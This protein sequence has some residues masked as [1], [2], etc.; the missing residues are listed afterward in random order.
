ML[1]LRLELI[2]GLR[3]TVKTIYKCSVSSVFSVMIMNN[4]GWVVSRVLKTKTNV[5]VK[6]TVKGWE[7]P[8]MKEA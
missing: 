1:K 8:K 7:S 3:S 2:V 6:D 5:D 4:E